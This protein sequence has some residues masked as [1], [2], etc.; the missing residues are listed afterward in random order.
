M[1]LRQPVAIKSALLHIFNAYV[2][3]FGIY[4]SFSQ[5]IWDY[6]LICYLWTS[7][8]IRICHRLKIY[9]SLFGIYAS[10][11]WN[12]WGFLWGGKFAIWC[13]TSGL[14]VPFELAIDSVLL[15]LARSSPP[16]P[17]HPTSPDCPLTF[18]SRFISKTCDT[19]HSYL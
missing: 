17:P 1:G 12:L 3:L 8:A 14:L 19:T 10:L 18:L 7:G 4:T 15:H 16:N 5:K 11:F 9:A 6:M 2:T 13:V